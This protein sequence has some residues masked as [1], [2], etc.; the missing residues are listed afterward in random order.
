MTSS[1][2]GY[3][4]IAKY[5]PISP[6]KVRPIANLIRSRSYIEA[7]AVLGTLPHKGAG[8]LLRTLRSAAANAMDLNKNINEESLFIKE[9]LVNEGTR[10]KRIWAR[11][12]GR[13]D[14]QLKRYAHI[15][16]V[17]DVK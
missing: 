2:T 13:A 17:L 1:T 10:H 12:R 11:G 8:F 15:A 16:V 3:K 4:A 9:L 7:E 6:S 14:R 5:L